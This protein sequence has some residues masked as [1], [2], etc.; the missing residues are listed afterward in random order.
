MSRIA[1]VNG[2]YLP[3]RDAAVHIEDRGYQFSDGI[4]EVIGVTG[5]RILDEE[6]HLDRLDRSLGALSIRWP[7]SRRALKLILREVLRRNY[8]RDGIVYIQMNRGV[9]PRDHAFP[10]NAA[11]SV[12]ITARRARAANPDAQRKGVAVITIPDIR[13]QRCDIKTIG[14]LPNVLG[15]QQALES[16]AFEAWMAD[17]DG[18][19]TEG[20]AT[21]AWIV[22]ADGQLVTRPTDRT[23]LSGVT[24]ASLAAIVRLSGIKLSERPFTVEEAKRAREAFITSTTSYVTP[25]VSIDGSVVG[26]GTP[27]P[28]TRKLQDWYR[29]YVAGKGTAA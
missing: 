5:G 6:P 25:V 26:D 18:F 22:T 21:N 27:G 24:R 29:S 11:P 4:Y 19:V 3:H 7:M 17:S 12:V 8:V 13:W 15:K 23:I 9:A 28:V 20:T 1:Y 2:R 16:G 10:K 14:L